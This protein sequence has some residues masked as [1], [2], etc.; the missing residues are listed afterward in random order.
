MDEV[1]LAVPEPIVESL[2]EDGAASARDMER[3]V[4]GRQ[5]RI[6][7]VIRES[8]DDAAAEEV[9]RA[10]ERMEE[11]I[12]RYDAFVPELRAWGSHP[13]TPSPGGPST[14]TSSDS[15]TGTSTSRSDSTASAAP[16]WWNTA[17]GCGTWRT[18]RGTAVG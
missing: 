11:C 13:S 16:A 1:H 15:C 10:I 3:A 7:R 9:L 4:E 14:P 12:E 17:S 5:E 8:D 2:P 18:E 6:N